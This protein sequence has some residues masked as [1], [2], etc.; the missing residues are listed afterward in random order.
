LTKLKVIS[1]IEHEILMKL[2]RF[3]VEY[4]HNILVHGYFENNSLAQTLIGNW[5]DV[6]QYKYELLKQLS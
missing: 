6:M 1:S 2:H 5:I 4:N 3:C